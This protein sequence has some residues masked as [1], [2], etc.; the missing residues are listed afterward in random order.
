MGNGVQC[1][2][3]NECT[4][5]LAGCAVSATCT[6]TVG[7]AA[8]T[9]NAGFEGDGGI[10]TD[11]NE[12]VLGTAGCDPN[13]TCSNT[14]GGSSCACNAGYTGSGMSCALIVVSLTIANSTQNYDAFV[15][16]GSPTS[17][18]RVQ[19]TVNAGVVLSSAQAGLPA[20][21]S[22]ALPAGSVVELVNNGTIIGAGGAAGRGGGIDTRT[23]QVSFPALA[24]QAG[25][26]AVRSTVPITITN[27]G[28][29]FGG[30]G[31]GGGGAEIHAV[32]NLAGGGG[33]A[34]GAGTVGGAGA[35]GGPGFSGA[36]YADGAAGSAGGVG[37]GTPGAG[38]NYANIGFGGSGGSGGAYG[39]AG[40][41][42][43]NSNLGTVGAL[44]GAAGY[45]VRTDGAGI[46]WV[47]GNNSTLVKGPQN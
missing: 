40:G 44:G 8:C 24:G 9:C 19:V 45:S 17:P 5:N 36:Q 38:G 41:Q 31:G 6:N 26:A 33:G 20:F 3:V 1:T 4:N 46:T 22:G 12:C 25:G 47:S 10:C 43:G 34:G 37:P 23:A 14:D 13:A 18:R 42:G 15:Q 27:A 7:S 2:D 30:G 11:L 29:I 21:T 16:A 28:N 35:A 32:N 39:A